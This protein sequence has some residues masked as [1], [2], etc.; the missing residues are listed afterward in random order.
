MRWAG[1]LA[2]MGHNKNS[3]KL[4]L[5]RREEKR[6]LGSSTCRQQHSIET[7][8]KETA[9]EGMDWIHLAQG[10]GGSVVDSSEHDNE[11]SI[12]IKCWK[13]LQWLRKH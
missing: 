3:N 4:L 2:H 5:E 10:R 13:F 6:P 12:F 11:T 9:W 7:N 1:H 8:L